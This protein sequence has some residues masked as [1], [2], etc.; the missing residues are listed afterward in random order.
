MAGNLSTTRIFVTAVEAGAVSTDWE[1]KSVIVTFRMFEK[2]RS[3]DTITLAQVVEDLTYQIQRPSTR[4]YRGV[5]L[6]LVDPHFGLVALSWDVSLLLRYA[7][8]V[9]GEGAVDR[10]EINEGSTRFCANYNYTS[11]LQAANPHPQHS[12]NGSWWATNKTADYRPYCQFELWYR[13]DLARAL[14]IS[15][16]RIQVLFIKNASLDSVL[17]HT[18]FSPPNNWTHA[19]HNISNT[20]SLLSK[21]V[22][23]HSYRPASV[24]PM[25]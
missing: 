16:G 18:R 4:F 17:V 12:S 2:H 1:P 19:E 10:D 22:S 25:P 13:Q 7:L 8:H 6:R 11:S 24:L 21:Q 9:V 5:V 15:L 14:N 3:N 23:S 20:I